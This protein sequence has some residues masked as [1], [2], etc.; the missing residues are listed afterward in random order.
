MHQPHVFDRGRTTSRQVRRESPILPRSNP[1]ENPQRKLMDSIAPVVRFITLVVLITAAA[2]W[3]QTMGRYSAPPANV[4]QPPTTTVEERVSPATKTA[5]RPVGTPTAI[6]PART[7][8]ETNRRV[9]RSREHKPHATLRGDILSVPAA[10]NI[11]AGVSTAAES[12]PRLQIAEL[13][14]AG[15]GDDPVRSETTRWNERVE[16]Q[17]REA[18]Q[19]PGFFDKIP[20]R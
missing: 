6:G 18:R 3:I 15:V 4:V 16:Q 12:L 8:P 10:E 11:A 5:E 19:I 2:T 20:C 13:P 9:G 7:T 14:K 17:I 1:F